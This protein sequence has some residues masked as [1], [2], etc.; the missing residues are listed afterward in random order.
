MNQTQTFYFNKN[1]LKID[2]D[3]NVKRETI[4]LLEDNMK[5]NLDDH[6]SGDALLDTTPKIQFMK[7]VIDNLDLNRI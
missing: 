2:Q 3:L 4:E 5:E 1:W 6:K 7:E